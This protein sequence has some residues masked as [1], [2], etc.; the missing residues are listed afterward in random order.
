MPIVEKK[1]DEFITAEIAE[2]A[3]KVLVLT[4][5]NTKGTKKNR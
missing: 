1:L 4:T 5:K 2:S 3:E